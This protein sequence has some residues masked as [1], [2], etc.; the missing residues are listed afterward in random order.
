MRKKSIVNEI[1]IIRHFIFCDKIVV[2]SRKRHDIVSLIVLNIS[3]RNANIFGE[4]TIEVRVPC[5]D[6]VLFDV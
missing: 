2:E 6:W 3:L 5:C 4:G 1:I